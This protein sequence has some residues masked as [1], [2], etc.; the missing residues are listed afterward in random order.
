M[1]CAINLFDY[2]TGTNVSNTGTWQFTSTTG[3]GP[4]VTLNVDGAGDAV[5]APDAQVGAGN[6][7]GVDFN[8]TET[9]VVTFTYTVTGDQGGGCTDTATLDITV[10]NGVTAG[11]SYSITVCSN[12]NQEYNLYSF[13]T[14]GTDGTSTGAEPVSLPGGTVTGSWSGDVGASG[15][16]AGTADIDDDTF[17]PNGVTN[18]VYTYT[19]SVAQTGAE[20]CENCQDS[21][22]VTITVVTAP[23]A[24]TGQPAT[25]CNGTYA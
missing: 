11:V 6:N 22:T 20:S 8:S 3:S 13:L 4:N 5:Y 19:Y 14:G 9:G 16:T 23:E 25:V 7:P 12:T 10:V 24:G 2:I 15:Y 21:A 17:N 18:G 1:A